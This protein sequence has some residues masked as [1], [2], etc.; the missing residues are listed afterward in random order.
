MNQIEEIVSSLSRIINYPN[1][2]I[3]T[4]DEII[5]FD[6]LFMQAVQL[7]FDKNTMLTMQ[8]IW[9]LYQKAFQASKSSDF[10]LANYYYTKVNSFIDRSELPK[11]CFKYINVYATPNIAYFHYKKNDFLKA[12]SLLEEA[13]KNIEAIE[14][15]YVD[16]HMAK[17]QQLHNMSRLYL[18]INKYQE[19]LNIV[20]DILRY[21]S[22]NKNPDYISVWGKDFIDKCNPKIV[23]NM[24]S[25]VFF[26]TIFNM[27]L[28]D[29]LKEEIIIESVFLPLLDQHVNDHVLDITYFEWIK[30][31]EYYSKK[32]ISDFLQLAEKIIISGSKKL[33]PL[34]G[35]LLLKYFEFIKLN[36]KE[37][38]LLLDILN[39]LYDF[40]NELLS[41]LPAFIKE[42]MQA[43][44][45]KSLH[46]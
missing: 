15:D 27:I 12:L 5:D 13:I 38:R 42:M 44:I 3:D 8:Y 41:P 21:L 19:S 4:V 34:K 26:E 20:L 31:L 29:E 30:C 1:Q 7:K 10:I 2:V 43:E 35:Y 25:Q 36:E 46:L 32:N 18:K 45:K 11:D 28:I 22:S 16:M 17:I 24:F 14:S 23:S 6:S 37:N 39:K 9:S 33:Y 40:V